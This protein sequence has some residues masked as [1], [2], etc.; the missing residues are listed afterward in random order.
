MKDIR[1]T[2]QDDLPGPDGDEPYVMFVN[3][4]EYGNARFLRT[5]VLSA[6]PD[7]K[8]YTSLRF[9]QDVKRHPD[10]AGPGQDVVLVFMQA[11]GLEP[12]LTLVCSDLHLELEGYPVEQGAEIEIPL[13]PPG[14]RGPAKGFG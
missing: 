3:Q 14:S 5:N 13:L 2:T 1:I 12:P 6:R 9:Q 8:K 10:A 11:Q 7:L 4:N